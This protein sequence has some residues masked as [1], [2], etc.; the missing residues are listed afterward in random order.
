MWVD[1][2]DFRLSK[3]QAHVID[4]ISIGW[5]L[6][7]VGPGTSFEIDQTRV[8]N[9]TWMP[10]TITINGVAHVLFVH[11]RSLNEQ[12]TYSGYRP[13]TSVSAEKQ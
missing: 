7:R 2:Q 12:L 11:S 13:A 1:K 5:V 8:A 9:G 4:T 6:A 3:A 10:G